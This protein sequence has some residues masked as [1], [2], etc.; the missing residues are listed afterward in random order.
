MVR[1]KTKS[2]LSGETIESVLGIFQYA[3]PLFRFFNH[4]LWFD[5]AISNTV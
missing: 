4:G 3:V 5:I 2:H 1:L